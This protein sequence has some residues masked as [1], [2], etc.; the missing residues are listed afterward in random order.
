MDEAGRY[1]P[2][3]GARGLLCLP[4]PWT[5]EGFVDFFEAHD[6]IAMLE[7]SL[8]EGYLEEEG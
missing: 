6:F 4:E 8:E 7:E 5:G 1:P 3:L 2:E